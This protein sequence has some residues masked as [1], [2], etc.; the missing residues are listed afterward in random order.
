MQRI[1]LREPSADTNRSRWSEAPVWTVLRGVEQGSPCCEL[2]RERQEAAARLRLLRGFVGY[3]TSL[4][5]C[6]DQVAGVEEVL[7]EVVPGVQAYLAKKG[8]TFEDAVTI[9]R[10][11]RLVG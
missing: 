7:R 3:A 11:Q 2:V 8:T 10:E 5:A 4:A 6:D 1:S 9:K